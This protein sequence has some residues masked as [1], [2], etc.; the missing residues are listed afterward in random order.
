MLG[1]GG[2]CLG[3]VGPVLPWY[4]PGGRHPYLLGHLPDA[5]HAGAVQVAVVLAGLDEA[6]ALD[7]LLHLFP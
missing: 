5:L 1:S 2:L 7:V 3:V 4:C 6:V